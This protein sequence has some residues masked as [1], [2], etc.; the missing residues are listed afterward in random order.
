MLNAFAILL[1]LQLIGEITVRALHLP[2][3]GPVLGMLLLFF[4]FIWHGHVPHFLQQT[5]QGLLQHLSLFFVP[6]GVGIMVHIG[7]LQQE[8]LSITITLLGSTWITLLVTAWTLKTLLKIWE[9]KT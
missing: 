2:I 7:L 8:W 1:G 5:A 6:A 9:G 4:L 3:P